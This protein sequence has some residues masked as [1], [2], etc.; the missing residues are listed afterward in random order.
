MFIKTPPQVPELSPVTQEWYDEVYKSC[1]SPVLRLT[2]SNSWYIPYNAWTTTAWNI[3]K[4]DTHEIFPSQVG[5]ASNFTTNVP[6]YYLIHVEGQVYVETDVLANGALIWAICKNGAGL[7]L[8]ERRNY[9]AIRAGYDMIPYS[10]TAV[11]FLNGTTDTFQFKMK[12]TLNSVGSVWCYT[13]GGPAH[14]GGRF[15]SVYKLTH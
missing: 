13:P 12:Q 2:Y 8:R 5:I 4:H 11:V 1:S 9:N 14:N 7:N 3:V 15:M 10:S 6:G